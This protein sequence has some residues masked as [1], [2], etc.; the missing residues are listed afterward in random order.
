M[1]KKDKT[2]TQIRVRKEAHKRFRKKAIDKEMDLIDY[3]D[4]LS[5]QNL[6]KD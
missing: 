5:Y 1:N 6:T 3:M 4:L 2:T